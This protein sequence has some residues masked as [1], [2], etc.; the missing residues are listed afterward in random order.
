MSETDLDFDPDELAM[1]RQLFRSRGAR[2]ARGRD[3]ARARRRLGAAERRDADRDDARDAHA[4]GRG[5]HGR[6]RRDGRPLAPARERVRGARPRA[7]AVDAGDRRPDRRGHRRAARLPRRAGDRSGDGRAVGGRL[8]EQIERI[9]RPAG[10]VER[11]DS[12]ESLAPSPADSLAM[13]TS[14]PGLAAMPDRAVP[15]SR[16]RAGD[17]PARPT[18]ACPSRSRICASSPSASM[19]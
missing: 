11:R 7:V 15:R 2:C 3:H 9:A 13:P 1:L 4:Q 10:R 19:R 16:D 17:R 12:S 6:P 5:R 14:A 18:S 8:R